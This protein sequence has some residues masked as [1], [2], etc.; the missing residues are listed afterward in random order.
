MDAKKKEPFDPYVAF[1][2]YAVK[3]D[4]LRDFCD[5]YHFVAFCNIYTEN[6]V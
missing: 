2:K 4:N 3:A 6:G 1:Q 5:R